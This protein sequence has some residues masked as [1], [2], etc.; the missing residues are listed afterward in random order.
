MSEKPIIPDAEW[1]GKGK[2][3]RYKVRI[4]DTRRDGRVICER[5]GMPS[6]GQSVVGTEITVT[7][8]QLRAAYEPSGEFIMEPVK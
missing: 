8:E 6:A 2:G 1:V 4:L 7:P 5:T 3:N